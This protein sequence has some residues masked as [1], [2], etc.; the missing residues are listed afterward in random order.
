MKTLILLF[1]S[2]SISTFGATYTE[3]YINNAG[4]GNTNSGHTAD[5]TPTFSAQNG[6]WTNY[7]GYGVFF[8]S[9]MTLTGVTNGAWASVYTNTASTATAFV[10]I[11][12]NVDD[13]G[14]FIFVKTVGSCVG[15]PVAND[16]VGVTC[17]VVGGAWL[18][19]RSGT[20][21]ATS[22]ETNVFPTALVAGTLTNTAANIPRVNIRGGTTYAVTNAL[23][24]TGTGPVIWQGYTN[25]VGDMGR[26]VIDGGSVYPSY[27]L[28]TMTGLNHGVVD[29]VLQHNGA[30]GTSA[31]TAVGG[32]YYG[33]FLRVRVHGMG[34]NGL[35]MGGSSAGLLLIECEADGNNISNS[36]G[37]TGIVMG[38]G[39]MIGCVSHDN[40]GNATDG[41]SMSL[42]IAENCIAYNNGRNGFSLPGTFSIMRHCNS[43]SNVAC[44]IDLTKITQC[45]VVIENC[46][47]FRNKTFGIN[48]T[49]SPIR[50]GMI[51]NCAFGSGTMTNLSGNIGT[52]I[53][54]QANGGIDILNTLIYTADDTPWID[55]DNGNFTEKATALTKAVG[56]ASY[57]QQYL[58]AV[59]TLSYPDIGATQ[60]ASTNAATAGTTAH[61][62]AQ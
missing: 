59:T 8:K 27:V 32:T 50:S 13:T 23:N 6:F 40:V 30:S 26:A 52:T 3:F 7:T 48:S 14:D 47:V 2:I 10:G 29:L 53:T 24:I 57:G 15:T 37:G 18:G 62:F 58:G 44:G 17:I 55:P 5:A 35:S 36:S 20:A 46:A 43:Y 22:V 60:I 19:P 9:G 42:G 56:F 21:D 16:N 41:I 11:I 38:G 31:G 39:A 54:D 4:G 28:L 34:K 49:G 51:R 25:T 12:T 1:L 45:S 61:T 33:Y